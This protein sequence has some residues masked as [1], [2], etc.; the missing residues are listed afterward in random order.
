MINGT[1][2]VFDNIGTKFTLNSNTFIIGSSLKGYNS[3]NATHIGSY[4]PYLVR[5][6]VNP[7]NI[8][9]EVGL[10]KVVLSGSDIGVERVE[11]VESSN[12]NQPV[13]F[14]SDG[15]KTFFVFANEKNFN[16]G[17]NNIVLKN[18]DFSVDNV[19]A[20]YVVDVTDKT[21]TAQLPSASDN[22]GLEVRFK[23]VGDSSSDFALNVKNE[24]GVA[25][26]ASGPDR[27]LDLI[28]T[29]E[30]WIELKDSKKSIFTGDL[31]SQSFSA[32]SLQA[33]G[34]DRSL[35]FN[36]NSAISGSQIYYSTDNN[37]LLGSSVS[38]TAHTIIPVSGSGDVVFNNDNNINSNFFVKGSGNRSLVFTYDGRLGLNIPSGVRPAT[39]FHLIN[40][41]C[42]EGMRFEN[43][44]S[45]YPANI[46]LYHKPSGN[47]SSNSAVA[48]VTL[49]GKDSN[50]NKVD[51]ATIQ[52]K[53]VSSTADQTKGQLN[54]LVND[55]GSSV[56]ALNISP[57]QIYAGYVDNGLTINKDGDNILGSIND[58][59]TVSDGSIVINSDNISIGSSSGV[60]S[61]ENPLFYSAAISDNLQLPYIDD[62]NALLTVDSSG[63]VVAA[64]TSARLPSAPEGRILTTTAS[65]VIASNVSIND[66]FLTTKDLTWNKYSSRSANICLRQVAFLDADLPNV[67]EFII[68]DQIAIVTDTQTYYRQIKD[69]E[70]VNNQIVSLLVDQNLTLN[71]LANVKVYSITR[72]GYLENII[73]VEPG[74]VADSTANILSIRPSKDTVFNTKQ[75]NINFLVYGTDPVPSLEVFAS[76]GNITKMSGVFHDF[77]T[78]ENCGLGYPYPISI[79]SSGIGSSNFSNTANFNNTAS[80][81]WSGMV[82]QVGSNGK[83]SHYGT[84]DQNGNVAEWVQDTLNSSNNT[85]QYAAGGAWNTDSTSGLKSI[86]SLPYSSGYD[87]VGFR[88]SS[89][90]GLTDSQYVTQTL[91]LEFV[92]ITEPENLVDVSGLN[93]YNG[94]GY[95][96]TGI[97]DLGSVPYLYRISKYEVTNNQYSSFLNATAISDTYG[98]YNTSMGSSNVGGIARSGT[99]GSYSYV[100]KSGMADMPVAFVSYLSA[101][102]FTNWLHNGTPTDPEDVSTSTTEDGAYTIIS[103]QNQKLIERNLYTHYSL[104]TLNEW[105]KAA[106]YESD[107]GTRTTGYSAVTIKRSSPYFSTD[108]GYASLSVAGYLYADNMNIGPDTLVTEF[109][110]LRIGSTGNYSLFSPTGIRL[111]TSGNVVVNASGS[112]S[113]F[114]PTGVDISTNGDIR[115]K[116]GSTTSTFSPTGIILTTS[117]NT[118]VLGS[119]L[120]A[121]NI[122]TTNL[123]V[124]NLNVVDASGNNKDAFAGPIGGFIYKTSANSGDASSILRMDVSASGV[125]GIKLNG[126]SLSPLYL[127][128]ENFIKTYDKLTYNTN[129]ISAS[130]ANLLVSGIQIGSNNP[131]YSGSILTHNGN[132]NAYWAPAEYLNAEGVTWSRYE[133]RQVLVKDTEIVFTNTDLQTLTTEFPYSDTIAIMNTETRE[134]KYVKAAVGPYLAAGSGDI[135]PSTDVFYTTAGGIG[136]KYCP[137]IP[138]ATLLGASG[139]AFAVNRGGFLSMELEPSATDAFSCAAQAGDPNNYTFKPSTL[140]TI[141][142]RPGQAT[143]FNCLA[144]DIDFAIYGK[145]SVLFDAYD[146]EL[147]DS[148]DNGLP[149]GLIPALKINAHSNNSVSGTIQSGVMV[150]GFSNQTSPTGFHIDE[151]AKICINTK[152]P[153]VINTIPSGTG[154]LNFYADLTVNSCLYS[155]GIVTNAIRL[156]PVPTGNGSNSDYVVNMP[157]VINSSGLI[158]SQNPS[159]SVNDIW[160]F[161]IIAFTGVCT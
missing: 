105:H 67:P 72:G 88:V 87:Y 143:A 107:K 144:E 152:D 146:P 26:Y 56:S 54:I 141:S 157:L 43:R 131:F 150:S 38:A 82:S 9:W 84:Y 120:Y 156:L 111:S 128:S 92:N 60:V 90:D 147:F 160:D 23:T 94:S 158:V 122:Y 14:G 68:G 115:L 86:V 45:C 129:Q 52:S 124:T 69:L 132:G 78:E 42:Q 20:T 27:Y 17:F 100:V 16:V 13:N 81:S 31:S 3:L 83:A 126:T 106:Y 50:G 137:E 140:N 39:L 71:T 2:H 7:E 133:K 96:P 30:S 117:G 63:N 1:I 74:T 119:G 102:R 95:I 40:Y 46:T 34:N 51:Y 75:K 99:D 153:Y 103:T 28:S 19:N 53:A 58:N 22:Q 113:S 62:S 110:N 32:L 55:A 114:S 57:T 24:Q 29:G 89:A 48:T 66:Y 154:T 108:K 6:V 47:I 148:D 151:S 21:I 44:S 18:D 64:S 77:A 109:G 8:S 15:D 12:N 25:F 41:S 37:M 98:L 127:D 142:I 70:I 79:N 11:I 134:I 35:Q 145:K 80:G 91:G 76:A 33:E 85:S 149:Q 112:I 118:R 161:G 125:S 123:S 73:Y 136:M 104:P 97:A 139:S 130:N 121:E 36:N 135:D 101:I 116:A 5:N 65:G 4:I 10:G 93:L 49:A 61:I 155:S 59:I 159:N 138:W